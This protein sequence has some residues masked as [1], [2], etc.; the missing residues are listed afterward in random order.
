LRVISTICLY[1][2]LTTCHMSPD[3]LE[4]VR[5]DDVLRVVS[6]NSPTTYYLGPEGPTGPEYELARAFA[7]HLGVTLE[8]YSE[9]S[10]GG[11]L[12]DVVK[13]RADLAAA[14]LTASEG[15]AEGVVFGPEYRSV[16]E[17]LIY[18]SGNAR[19]EDVEDLY[20]RQ[21]GVATDSSHVDTLAR[22]RE[23]HPDLTW[24]EFP[25]ADQEE[26]L[27]RVSTGQLDF[28]VVDSSAFR[29]SRYFYPEARAAFDLSEPQPLGWALKFDELDDSLVEAVDEFF[30]LAETR[31]LI[32]RIDKRYFRPRKEFDYVGVR[33]FLEHVDIRL[34]K[35]KDIF[36]EAAANIGM[37]WR[38][39]AAIGYQESHWNPVAVSPTGV[40]GI[41]MLTQD[42]ARMMGVAD[43][44]DPRDSILG[45]ARYLNRVKNKIPTRIPEP[46]RTWFALAAYNI[47]FGHL[48]DARIITEMQDGDPDVWA[49]VRTSLP[50]L[51]QKKWYSRVKR[52]YA[53]GYAPVHYVDNVRSYYEALMW[54]TSGDFSDPVTTRAEPAEGDENNPT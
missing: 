37:D 25:T 14:G 33:T 48:E 6:R 2:L 7:D 10:I 19:P 53:R 17:T 1:L 22:L 3:L 21:L 35:Y 29:V 20:G 12:D 36:R 23:D 43:R 13:G 32:A 52:G 24:L 26:L 54:L 50:L 44:E 40:K 41:M 28:T 4:R 31:Q 5:D 27:G 8:I 11:I 51:T 9:D 46:D 18:S 15:R 38:L 39:L 49:D 45:G 30:H 42:T 34:P 16:T 47:G